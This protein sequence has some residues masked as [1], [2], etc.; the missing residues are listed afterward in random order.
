MKF[1]SYYDRDVNKIESSVF[2]TKS[3]NKKENKFHFVGI[4]EPMY[5]AFSIAD[6]G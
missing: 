6:V 2:I 1:F 3:H 5:I 4:Y